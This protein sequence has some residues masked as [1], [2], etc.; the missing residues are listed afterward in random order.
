MFTP[1][2][3]LVLVVVGFVLIGL[4]NRLYG[5][6][7]TRPAPRSRQ[8]EELAL[9]AQFRSLVAS[10]G[11]KNV[12]LFIDELREGRGLGWHGLREQGDPYLALNVWLVNASLHRLHVGSFQCQGHIRYEGTDLRGPPTVSVQ[13]LSANDVVVPGTKVLMA[14]RQE[15]LPDIVQD[16][17]GKAGQAVRLSLSSLRLTMDADLPGAGVQPVTW[18]MPFTADRWNGEIK[19]VVPAPAYFQR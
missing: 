2:G 9:A 19:A 16:I 18:G 11:S 6:S 10:D 1:A 4:S 7:V 14:I 15:L 8:G 12:V 13:G 3:T 17:R 5:G